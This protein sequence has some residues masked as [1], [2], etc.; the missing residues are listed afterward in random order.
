MWGDGCQ[1]LASN[2]HEI[3]GG[4]GIT[5]AHTSFTQVRAC[6]DSDPRSA[7]VLSGVLSEE[8]LFSVQCF[9]FSYAKAVYVLHSLS[10]F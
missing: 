5:Q 3:P 2:W 7:E 10:G 9:I 1:S 4:S 8:L 6:A